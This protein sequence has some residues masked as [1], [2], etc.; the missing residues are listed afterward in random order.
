[1]LPATDAD[2]YVAV[3]AVGVNDESP[4][5]LD[6][7]DIDDTVGVA[8]ETVIVFTTAVADAYRS[9][10]AW[11]AVRAQEPDDTSDSVATATVQT[12]VFPEVTTGVNPEDAENVSEIVL[13]EYV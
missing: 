3:G 7:A 6:C 2:W 12:A 1:M 5:V 4:Y 9:S 11:F 8:F 13:D 10:P